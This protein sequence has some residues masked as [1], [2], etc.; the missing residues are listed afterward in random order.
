MPVFLP[1]KYHGQGSLAGYIVHGAA[2]LISI[3]FLPL[4]AHDHVTS[5]TV[6]GRG[7]KSDV[8]LLHP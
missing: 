6:T 1:G 7:F 3:A 8:F 2:K 4:F 5:L